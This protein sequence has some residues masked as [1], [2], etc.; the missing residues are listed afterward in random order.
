MKLNNIGKILCI[1]SILMISMGVLVFSKEKSLKLEMDNREY[2]DANVLN[3]SNV[4]ARIDTSSLDLKQM[5]MNA[6]NASLI[7][8]VVFDNLTMEELSAKL[9]RVVGG[10]M[11]GKGNLI[12]TESIKRGVDPYVATAIMMHETGN[13]TSSMCRTCFNFGGQKGSG[14]GAYQ[15]FSSTDEGLT[16][17][18]D[19]LYRN[20][21][22]K[23]L[24]TIESIG[25]RYAESN[26]WPSMIHKYVNKIKSS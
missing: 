9:N 15:R 4:Q 11:S 24:T 17:M 25:S 7:R 21:Y 23:G 13:G 26:T 16:R 8:I 10:A 20:Y 1:I 22:A 19:N 3:T 14:C 2:S 6:A 5:N 18:I 12:A